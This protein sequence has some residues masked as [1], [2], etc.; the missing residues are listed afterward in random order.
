PLGSV[1]PA[2]A[3]QDDC[4]RQS[5]RVRVPGGFAEANLSFAGVLTSG[6][7]RTG[8]SFPGDGLRELRLIVSWTDVEKMH[9]QRIEL[10]SPDGELYQRFATAFA[11]GGRTVTVTTRLP[12]TGS[13]ITDSGLYGEWCAEVYLDDDDAPIARR[14]FFLVAP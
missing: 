13:S 9:Q 11:G 3:D 5:R 4:S 10:L 2:R 1:A 7:T 14:R 6:R 8:E 12:V